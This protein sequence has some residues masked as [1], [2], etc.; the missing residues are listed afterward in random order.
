M[1]TLPETD[2]ARRGARPVVSAICLL[3]LASPLLVAG[4]AGP[5]S[6]APSAA[7]PEVAPEV[8]PGSVDPETPDAPEPPPSAAV[9][10]TLPG[11]DFEL[12]GLDGERYR[13]SSFRG[14]VLLINFWATWCL[15]CRE[16]L[17]ALERVHREL[18]DQGVVI[19]GIATDKGGRS[20][21]APYVEEMG[22]TYTI[23]LDPQE[24]S[25]ALFGGLTGYP[26]TFIID[27][28][29]LIYSSYLGAQ[30]EKTFADD[31]H[32]LLQA[33]PSEGAELPENAI[34]DAPLPP[35]T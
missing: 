27:R 8:A 32:Y 25:T 11:P 9:A 4:C 6:E 15:S 1:A 5:G 23:L 7:A 33:Q 14:Q 13:L 17:P 18:A 19:A 34:S 29:G 24:V 22:L 3:L 35:S 31:L 28:E 12:L 20:I 26:S 16:E 2:G 21:V 30:E 10:R